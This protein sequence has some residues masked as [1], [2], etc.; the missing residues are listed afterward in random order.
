MYTSDIQLA[1]ECLRDPLAFSKLVNQQRR[2]IKRLISGIVRQPAI[3]EELLQEV[4][5][6]VFNA[7]PSYAGRSALSTW[8]WAIARN[9]ALDYC[10]KNQVDQCES[11]LDLVVDEAT[12]SPEDSLLHREKLAQLRSAVRQL[13]KDQK[14]LVLLTNYCELPFRDVSRILRLKTGTIMSRSFGARLR[15]RELIGPRGNGRSHKALSSG[16]PISVIHLRN[17][18]PATVMAYRWSACA[19][20]RTR[21][22]KYF[23]YASNE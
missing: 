18:L 2:P 19:I 4:F 3:T 1:R 5:L 13:P 15:L 12:P 21:P 7:L 8:I 22:I 9:T 23:R 11:S 16:S 20:I 14:I 17:S 6:R 10:S